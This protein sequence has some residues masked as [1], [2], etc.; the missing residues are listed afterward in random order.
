[1]PEYA[2]DIR[3]CHIFVKPATIRFIFRKIVIAVR[4]HFT[5]LYYMAELE[6]GGKYERV[7]YRPNPKP[8][9]RART[10]K[11]GSSASVG[12]KFVM[13]SVA[14]LEGSAS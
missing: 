13:F 6:G 3:L 5:P 2:D 11:K 1:M 4:C 10:I 7:G 14:N 8:I 9:K 12:K